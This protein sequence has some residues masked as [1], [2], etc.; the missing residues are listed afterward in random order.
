MPYFSQTLLNPP[1]HPVDDPN[2]TSA[3]TLLLLI[4]IFAILFGHPDF[5]IVWFIVTGL[6]VMA[7]MPLVV[8]FG[9]SLWVATRPSVT[10]G[11]A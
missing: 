10:A 2:T 7:L 4:Y 3:L 1:E 8:A 5:G 6:M 11:V 9:F